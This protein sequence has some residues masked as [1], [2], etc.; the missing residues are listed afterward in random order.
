MLSR[1]APSALVFI[2]IAGSLAHAH[3]PY[4]L[5][6]AFEVSE[7]DHVSVQASLTEKFFVPDVVMKATNWHVVS[8]DGQ[9]AA[10]VPV[11]TKDLAVLDVDTKVPGTYRISTGARDG[12]AAK[13]AIAGDEWKSL[14][15]NEAPPAGPMVYAI[16]SVTLAESH[17]DALTFEVGE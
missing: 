4:L 15:G 12:R 16:R 10:L 3:S 13:D 9:S 17:T 2:G 11:Y 6:N 14:R 1:L 5:P 7:R 8:P